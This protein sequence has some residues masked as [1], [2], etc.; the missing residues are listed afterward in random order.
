MQ[1]GVDAGGYIGFCRMSTQ[2]V[3]AQ[4]SPWVSSMPI[5]NKNP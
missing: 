2:D 4:D 1:T 5:L 3:A